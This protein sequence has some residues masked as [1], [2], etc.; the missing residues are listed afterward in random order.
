MLGVW[1]GVPASK[2]CGVM[3]MSVAAWSRWGYH[4]QQ[5]VQEAQSAV[6]AV[7]M[8]AESLRSSEGRHEM[9]GNWTGSGVACFSG[10]PSGIL[11]TNRFT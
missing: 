3:G 10:A 11:R 7:E 2:V 6:I 8:A 5:G 1:T 4:V 9:P